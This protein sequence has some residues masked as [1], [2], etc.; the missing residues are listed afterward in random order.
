MLKVVRESFLSLAS[1]FALFGGFVLVHTARYESA[2]ITV[3][4]VAAAAISD[5]AA[6]RLAASLRFRTISSEDRVAFDARAFAA[7]HAY[8]QTAFPRVHAQLQ[9]E[10]VAT[11]SL[12]YTWP[13]SDP[14]LKPMLLMGH[15]DVVP[16]E[17][18]TEKQWQH[19]PFSGRIAGGF[20]WGRGAIDNKSTV[21]GTLEAV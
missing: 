1:A 10:T 7:F 16:V 14:S 5:G 3:A 6:E 9:R 12:L 17:P 8:L 13:G 15:L 2:Q 11:H 20:I 21:I 4:P 19:D 18:D